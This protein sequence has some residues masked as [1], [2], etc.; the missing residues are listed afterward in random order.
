ML[1]RPARSRAEAKA[2]QAA[3]RS[4]LGSLKVLE[5]HWRPWMRASR[6]AHNES[7]KGALSTGALAGRQTGLFYKR[8]QAERGKG[9]CREVGY[10]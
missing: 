5:T 1:K 3:S 9:S 2:G 7:E 6:Q 4:R 8:L 10:L